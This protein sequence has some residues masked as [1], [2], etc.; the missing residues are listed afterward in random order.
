MFKFTKNTQP[1]SLNHCLYHKYFFMKKLSSILFLAAIIAAILSCN[2][3]DDNITGDDTI[4]SYPQCLSALQGWNIST[5]ET[6]YGILLG[7]SF[8]SEQ[9]GYLV[10][11]GAIHKTNNGGGTWESLQSNVLNNNYIEDFSSRLMTA[12]YFVNEQLGYVAGFGESYPG[13]EEY[14][15][16]MLLK[17]TNG[18]QTWTKSYI[19]GTDL[20]LDLYF[21]DAQNGIGLFKE[22]NAATGYTFYEILTTNNG[23]ATW[24]NSNT[25]DF[26]IGSVNFIKIPNGEICITALYGNNSKL[27]LSTPDK[28]LT[29]Q[30][31]CPLPNVY[32]VVSFI[33][34]ETGFAL[35]H[36]GTIIKTVNGGIYWSEV[37][38]PAS[39][40]TILHFKTAS[41]GLVL[42][43]HYSFLPGDYP[44]LTSY[45][46]YQTN[47]GGSTWKKTEMEKACNFGA[48][49]KIEYTND[50][51][52]V[53]GSGNLSKFEA[54]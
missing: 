39:L 36:D 19:Q 49:T 17:T 18:G 16:A 6:P 33:D 35:T 46:A 38:V 40:E 51:F 21:F 8:P 12:C 9:V 53:L 30:V 54:Q 45:E 48:G 43:P 22:I 15:G 52:F 20:L 23:G 44:V 11:M 41:E 47:D 27:L 3:E 4:V 1:I 13:A 25:S 42:K 14:S 5:N 31:K 34:S 32:N 50:K 29:W 24:K 28:G 37:D 7:L 2:K 10:G 26:E